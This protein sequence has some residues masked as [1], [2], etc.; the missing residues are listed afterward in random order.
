M[1]KTCAEKFLWHLF[2]TPGRMRGGPSKDSVWGKKPRRADVRESRSKRKRMVIKRRRLQFS[3]ADSG[4]RSV[5]K[6]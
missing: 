5:K 2:T 6:Y 4:K 1:L 3:S